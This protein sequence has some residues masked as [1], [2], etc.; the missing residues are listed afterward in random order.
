MTIPLNILSNAAPISPEMEASPPD[1]RRVIIRVGGIVQ[2]VGFRPFIFQLAHEHRLQGWVRNQ[3]DGVEIDVSGPSVRIDRLIR[4][5]TARTPPLARIL[6][7]VVEE[8][9]PIAC[10]GFAIVESLASEGRSTLISPDVCVCADCLRELLDPQDRRFL[11]PFI[12]CTNCGPRYTIIKDI[13]YDRNRT[14]MAGFTMCAACLAEYEDPANRRFHAQPNACWECGP[15]VWLEES[16]GTLMARGLEAVRD[17]VGL[18]EKGAVLAVKGL[19]GFHLAVPAADEA[20]VSR[21]RRRKIREEKPFAV[22]FRDLDAVREVCS[23][24]DRESELLLTAAR[25]IVLLRRREDLPAPPIAPSVAPDNKFLGAFLPYTPLHHLLFQNSRYAA[26]VLTS[27]N[28]SDEPIVTDNEE[29]RERLRNIADYFLFH[30]RDIYL[31][32]DDSVTRVLR[33]EPRPIRRARGY[34]PAPIF[35]RESLPPVLGVGAE[36][37][38]TVCLT[39]GREAFLSQHVGD[40][41]NLETLHSFEHTVDHLSRILEVQPRLIACDLHPDYLST[42]WALARHDLP[43]VTVQ[44]HHAHIASVVAERNLSGPVLGLA[45]NGTGYG[46]D[47]TIWGGEILW[48]EDDRFQRLGHFRHL[49]MPGGAQAIREPWRMALSALWALNPEGVEDEYRDFLER[50]P[51]EKVT[52]TLQMLRKGFHS[53]ATSSCGRLFDAV[54]ALAGIRHTITYEG[55]AAIQLE[56]AVIDHEECYRGRV[57]QENGTW[58]LDGLDMIR[59]VV[60]DVRCGLPT[61]I[62]AARFHNG[63]STLLADAAAEIGTAVGIRNI[64]LSGG[65]FQ[66]ATLLERLEP[67][68][69]RLGF[70]VFSHFEVPANDACIALGQAYVAAHRLMKG[71]PEALPEPPREVH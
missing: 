6:S 12:N 45:M 27:G 62:I 32:C 30:N 2:G 50:W 4:D 1:R 18:L 66:N 63:L 13:P 24:S 52:V 46:P 17:A 7:L 33:G 16:A 31:R 41:E 20:H 3:P 56:Q 40:L 34:V 57:T 29:A 67:E 25:P 8:K 21:L 49:R 61:G 11:Y 43:R 39:R 68:L 48:V 58:I 26:L 54:A 60:R 59:A 71:A 38:N 14:T 22:M 44:H 35:L 9:P 51:R 64:A 23:L 19:G 37:K 28:Q 15:Q 69:E 70:S 65:V 42:Q 53:P 10:E 47:G 55:Q 5:I 36:L